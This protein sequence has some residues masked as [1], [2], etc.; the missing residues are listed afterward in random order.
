[1]QFFFS[2]PQCSSCNSSDVLHPLLLASAK[3]SFVER[4]RATQTLTLIR[5]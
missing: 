5:A 3:Y 2:S 1:M 4:I